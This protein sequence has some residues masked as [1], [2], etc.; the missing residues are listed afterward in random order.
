MPPI[1]WFVENTV[2]E[3]WARAYIRAWADQLC[4]V[5]SAAGILNTTVANVIG[6]MNRGDLYYIPNFMDAKRR[7]LLIRHQVEQL[8]LVR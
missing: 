2:G 8:A 4:A 5:K 6:Y 3:L 7:R 1:Q